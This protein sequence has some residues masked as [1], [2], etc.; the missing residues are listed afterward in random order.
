VYHYYSDY[1]PNR[2]LKSG[3]GFEGC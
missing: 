2:A 3:E 1:F